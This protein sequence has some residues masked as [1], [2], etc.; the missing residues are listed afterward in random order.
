MKLYKL[1][2]L[3]L[4]ESFK[5]TGIETRAIPITPIKKEKESKMYMMIMKKK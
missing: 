3:S 2:I 5:P 1:G 4:S